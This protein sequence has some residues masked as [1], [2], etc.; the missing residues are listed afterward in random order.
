MNRPLTKLLAVTLSLLF[1]LTTMSRAQFGQSAAIIFDPSFPTAGQTVTA[2]TLLTGL[3]PSTATFRWFL[4]EKLDQTASGR[5]KET[6]TFKLGA[7]ARTTIDVVVIAPDGSELSATKAI[8]PRGAV[9]VWWTDTSVPAWFRGKAAPS[10]A[11]QVTVLAISGAGF[12]ERPEALFYSWNM[13]AEPQPAISGIGKDRFTLKTSLAE[14]VIHQIGVRISNAGQTIT[15]EAT[16]LIPTRRTEL[17]VYSIFPTGGVDF[18]KAISVFS[19]EAGE[20]FDFIAVPFFFRLDQIKSGGFVWQINSR[21]IE[22]Q[23]TRPN[24]LTIK[25]NPGQVSQ[26]FITASFRGTGT[27]IQEAISSFTANFR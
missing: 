9:L 4:N 10:P 21:P 8:T 24:L 26:N 15:Q 6:F 22:G 18:S 11:S 19:G 27:N 17:L 2:K 7:G 13:N 5:G 12:G 3:E 1:S 23:F 16:A 14:D 20:I 25:T